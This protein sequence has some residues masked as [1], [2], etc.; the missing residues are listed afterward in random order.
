MRQCC[1]GGFVT[2]GCYHDHCTGPVYKPVQ[3]YTYNPDGRYALYRKNGFSVWRE[4]AKVTN[5]DLTTG[6]YNVIE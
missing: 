6:K 3:E 4:S 1:E 5:E 2:A